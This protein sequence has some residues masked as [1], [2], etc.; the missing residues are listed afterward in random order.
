MSREDA[1]RQP[2]DRAIDYVA[3]N[4]ISDLSLRSSATALGDQRTHPSPQTEVRSMTPGF[5]GP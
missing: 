4:G 3:S 1:R 5:R 2:L